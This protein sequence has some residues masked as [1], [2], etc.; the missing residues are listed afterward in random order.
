VRCVPP[1]K[2]FHSLGKQMLRCDIHSQAPAAESF[3]TYR[4]LREFL[5]STVASQPATSALLLVCRLVGV[6]APRTTRLLLLS[7]RSG[8]SQRLDSTSHNYYLGQ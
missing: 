3:G 2:S 1:P 5:D 8:Y 4:K 7:L 6:L